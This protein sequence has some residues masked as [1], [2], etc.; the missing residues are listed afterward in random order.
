[1]QQHHRKL[2][3]QLAD[4]LGQLALAAPQLLG[5]QGKTAGFDQHRK[6]RQIIHLAHGLF[7]FENQRLP[8]SALIRRKNH[9][10]LKAHLNL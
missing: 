6:R 3:L 2:R 10:R 5:G 9:S 4:A 1:M 8:I 7:P